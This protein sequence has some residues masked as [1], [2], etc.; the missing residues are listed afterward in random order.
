MMRLRS[1]AFQAPY[2]LNWVADQLRLV[3]EPEARSNFFEQLDDDA[4]RTTD[5]RKPC[6]GGI[7]WLVQD[8][9]ATL[10]ECIDRGIQI[11][12]LK[13]VNGGAKSVQWAE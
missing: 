10:A 5:I 7:P 11:F 1:A 8:G 6:A 3:Y 2:P 9:R 4:V 13:T 12:N